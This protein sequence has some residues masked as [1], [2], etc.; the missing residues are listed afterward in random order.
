MGKFLK[1]YK[2]LFIKAQDDYKAAKYLYDGFNRGVIELNIE[3]ILFHM[4]QCV[5]KLLKS[6]LD[7][8]GV[9][10]PHTHDIDILIELLNSNNIYLMDNIERLGELTGFAVEGRYA[11]IC[12][13][14]ENIDEYIV[15]IDKLIKYIKRKYG[16]DI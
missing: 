9:K 14:V 2:I 1:L 8:N 13:D 6:I 3:I 12:D 5:E 10:F 16:E 15:I 11:I 7:F 4:Q